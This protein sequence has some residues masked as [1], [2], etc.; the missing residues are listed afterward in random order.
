MVKVDLCQR[1]DATGCHVP[2]GSEGGAEGRE[3]GGQEREETRTEGRV[4]G[5]GHHLQDL[6]AVYH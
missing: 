3:E 5:W 6:K 1:S 4:D 2:H